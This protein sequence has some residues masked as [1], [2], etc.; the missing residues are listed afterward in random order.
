LPLV[1]RGKHP[2]DSA[3]AM[4]VFLLPL[5]FLM[6]LFTAREEHAEAEAMVQEQCLERPCEPQIAWSVSQSVRAETTTLWIRDA[7][8]PRTQ[9]VPARVRFDV[10]VVPMATER[11]QLPRHPRGLRRR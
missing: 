8:V 2:Y 7:H 10:L 9:T 1:V 5:L 4:Q 3:L 6:M 11:V